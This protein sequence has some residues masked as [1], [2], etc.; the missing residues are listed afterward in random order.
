[1]NLEEQRKDDN[2]AFQCYCL[3]SQDIKMILIFKFIEQF[4]VVFLSGFH[5]HYSHGPKS[6]LMVY[7]SLHV[8]KTTC[9]VQ[10]HSH[11]MF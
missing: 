1:M 3:F 11:V 2:R 10:S 8:R 5:C 7:S 9:N 4:L 6:L